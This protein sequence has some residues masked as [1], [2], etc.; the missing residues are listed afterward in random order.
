MKT[1]IGYLQ[2]FGAIVVL[3]AV[4]EIP[5]VHSFSDWIDANR[6]WL[7][8]LTLGGTGAGF[9]IMVWGWVIVGIKFGRPMTEEEARQYMS[10]PIPGPG[11]QSFSKGRFKG[12][13]R[14]RKVDP[15]VEWSFQEMKAAWHAGAWWREPDMRRKYFITAGGLLLI[16]S[17]F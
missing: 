12:V 8:T 10:Q 14:G 6:S 11:K 2:L 17:G 7:L 15:P 3:I 13:A 9:L 1:L 5:A 16:L 4:G